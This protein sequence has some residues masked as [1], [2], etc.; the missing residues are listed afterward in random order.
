MSFTLVLIIITA[1]V[2]I[3]G[4]SQP[5]FKHKAIL[6]P[7]QVYHHKEY[8]RM[9]SSGFLHADWTHLFVNM[10]VLYIFGR[11]LEEASQFYFG[12]WGNILFVV[13]YL[14]AIPA[15]NISTLLKYRDNSYYAS[16]GASGAVSAVLFAYILLYPTSNLYLLLLPIPVNAVI[17]GGLYLLYSYYMAKRGGD[18]INHEAHFYGALFGIAFYVVLKPQLVVLFVQQLRMLL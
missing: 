8:H 13:M 9:I 3:Q 5:A 12:Q 2:S 1:I 4:F 11:P 18:H 17:M 7:T 10:W 6:L 15:A 16:L 14:L